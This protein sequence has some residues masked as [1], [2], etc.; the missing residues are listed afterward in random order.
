[1]YSKN[2]LG[3]EG[4]STPAFSPREISMPALVIWP[5]VTPGNTT[6]EALQEIYRQAYE[7]AQALLRP[8]VYEL[9]SRVVWN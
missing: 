7:W 4:A 6:S 2:I 5:I 8:S 1:M 9:A 3:D